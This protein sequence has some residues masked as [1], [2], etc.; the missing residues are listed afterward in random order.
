MEQLIAFFHWLGIWWNTIVKPAP[1]SSYWT[2]PQQYDATAIWLTHG[3]W[4]ICSVI[5]VVGLYCFCALA[6]AD[7]TIKE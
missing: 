1:D 3:Q 2:D 6:W 5:V 7:R 4:V